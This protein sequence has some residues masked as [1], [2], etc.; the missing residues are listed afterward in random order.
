MNGAVGFG[1][2][3]V[4]GDGPR[5]GF[6]VGHDVLDLATQG[7]GSVFEASEPEPVPRA[8][9]AFLGGHDGAHT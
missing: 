7:L 9:P 2:F 4:G 5:V 3:S 1:V 6:R 8:R